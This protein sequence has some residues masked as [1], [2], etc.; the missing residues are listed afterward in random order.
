MQRTFKKAMIERQAA[1]CKHGQSISITVSQKIRSHQVSTCGCS[2]ASVFRAGE[3]NRKAPLYTHRMA[4]RKMP[5]NYKRRQ[6]LAKMWRN[7]NP[8]TLRMGVNGAATSETSP[9]VPQNSKQ[10]GACLTTSSSTSR[11]TRKRNENLRPH[12]TL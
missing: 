9:A 6:V 10:R 8:Q 3:L 5:E 7:G 2:A 4:G 11:Y 12:K 1:Q